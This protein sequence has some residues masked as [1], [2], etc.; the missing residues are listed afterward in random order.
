MITEKIIKTA[1]E[2]GILLE[3]NVSSKSEKCY[4]WNEFWENAKDVQILCGL[5]AHSLAEIDKV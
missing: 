1:R 2:Y 4:Y 3:Q 5:D